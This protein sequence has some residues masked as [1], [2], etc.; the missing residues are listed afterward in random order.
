MVGLTSTP[1]KFKSTTHNLFFLVNCPNTGDFEI[2]PNEEIFDGHNPKI[3]DVVIIF[4]DNCVD[5]SMN[6]LS[7]NVE[8][9]LLQKGFYSKRYAYVGYGAAEPYIVTTEKATWSDASERGRLQKRYNYTI[10]CQKTIKKTSVL[11]VWYQRSFRH[12]CD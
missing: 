12:R 8:E 10:Y 1:K 9:A 4:D 6:D 3:V 2:G 7:L 11:Q 5:G